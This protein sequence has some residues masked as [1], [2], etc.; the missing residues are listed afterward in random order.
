[1]TRLFKLRGCRGGWRAHPVLSV[2]LLGALQSS[3]RQLSV[4]SWPMCQGAQGDCENGYIVSTFTIDYLLLNW[5]SDNR[6]IK[7]IPFNLQLL[8]CNLDSI[9]DTMIYFLKKGFNWLF[10]ILFEHL[11]I[12]STFVQCIHSL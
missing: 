12:W 7:L 3:I 4:D 11:K 8:Y 9:W 2:I 5:Y 6:L 10:W 1:M